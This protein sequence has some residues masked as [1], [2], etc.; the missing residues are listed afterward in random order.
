[1]R[2]SVGAIADYKDLIVW[3]KAFRLCK[4]VF[5]LASRLPS[6]DKYGLGHQL[7]KTSVSIPSN[8]AEGNGR[9]TT[10]DY[11]RFLWIARGSACELDT[12]LL[13]M[14][15]IMHLPECEFTEALSLVDECKKMLFSMIQS[16]KND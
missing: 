3:Q 9:G 2:G 11:I 15:E 8:I 4:L 16:L 6:E 13:L 10:K 12:Q 7:R 5:A 14:R 1:M